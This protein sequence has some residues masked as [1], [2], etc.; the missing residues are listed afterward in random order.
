MPPMKGA[1]HARASIELHPYTPYVPPS[2]SP[3]PN[4]SADGAPLEPLAWMWAA[5]WSAHE[6]GGGY[7]LSPKW[8]NFAPTRDAA[9][10][11]AITEIAGRL[12][13]STG[14]LPAADKAIMR[15]LEDLA[16]EAGSDAAL[17]A[18]AAAKGR[19]ARR[20]GAKADA[21]TQTEGEA[22]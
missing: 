14:V 17:P 19:M 18:R 1:K 16:R 9:L 15:W 2:A 6:T 3:P 5:N 13:K 8:R 21:S 22:A 7:G 11:A 20:K 10:K 4:L 12:G